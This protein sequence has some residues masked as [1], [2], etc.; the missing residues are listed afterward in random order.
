MNN[1]PNRN[2][3]HKR[4]ITSLVF[5]VLFVFVV[6]L[7][8][9][10]IAAVLL[11]I[12]NSLGMMQPI[13]T[14]RM[15][16]LLA[17]MLVVSLIVSMI[18]TT[19]AGNLSLRPLMKFIEATKE[20]AAGNFNVRVEAGGPEEFKR[21]AKSFNEMAKELGSIETLRDD[22][23][24]NISHEFKT[25][26]VS[27]RGFAKLLR[28]GGLSKEQQDEYLDIIITESNRLT[29]L[30]SNV[31]LLS[32][33]DSTDKLND[34]AE[35]SLD[36]QLRQVIL[37]LEQQIE[38]KH[39]DVEVELESCT[40]ESSQELLQQVWINLLN[41]A[42]KF[43]PE[44]GR[45]EVLLTT[46]PEKVRVSIKDTGIGMDAATAKHIFDKFYQGEESRS[47]EG[48]GLGLSLVKKITD[49]CGGTVEI[50]SEPGRGS[51]FIVTIPQNVQSGYKDDPSE[52][53]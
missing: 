24:S 30:S 13:S 2:R 22:F 17:F 31:L 36:E 9:M 19:I 41:N 16:T 32:K 33:L 12:I 20:I 44:N 42:V 26:V 5:L 7:T 18:I 23:V 27:I 52:K 50:S 48:N 3:S 6:L 8:S 43:T 11:I 37:L 51:E 21:L 29:Q 4:K 1:H 47:S 15:P 34:I 35:F 38:N 39:I 10:A 25:P 14:G 53:L 45:I 49:L 46:L 28:K 40:V